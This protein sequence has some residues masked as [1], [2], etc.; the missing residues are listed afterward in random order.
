MVGHWLP[1]LVFSSQRQFHGYALCATAIECKKA[2]DSH[3]PEQ[4]AAPAAAAAAATAASGAAFEASRA[5]RRL[6]SFRPAA[7]GARGA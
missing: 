7:A 5:F 3:D 2:L 6:P 1:A 4:Q